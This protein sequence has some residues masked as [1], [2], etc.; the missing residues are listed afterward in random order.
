MYIW[1]SLKLNF[2]SLIVYILKVVSFFKLL[3]LVI[4]LLPT[5]Y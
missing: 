1:R 2:L 5:N 4:K 3:V